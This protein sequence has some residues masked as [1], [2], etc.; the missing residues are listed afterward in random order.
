[1][2][3][4]EHIVDEH[5]LAAAVAEHA[6][7]RGGRQVLVEGGEGAADLQE[8]AKSREGSGGGEGEGEGEG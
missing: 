4:A 2:R 5:V 1:V 7:P 6:R 8:R 3:G